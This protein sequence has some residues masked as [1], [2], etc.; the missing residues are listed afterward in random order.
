MSS[1]LS[2]SLLLLPPDIGE[3]RS[4]K[5]QVEWYWICIKKQHTHGHADT[6]IRVYEQDNGQIEMGT[7]YNNLSPSLTQQL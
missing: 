1:S 2:S 5:P 6:F 4:R 7:Y 3:V